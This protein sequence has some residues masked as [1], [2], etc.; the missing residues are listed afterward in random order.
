MVRRSVLQNIFREMVSIRQRLEDI[1]TNF[2][3]WSI[4]PLDL[5]E[6]ELIALPDHLRR[7]IV[8]VSSKGECDASQVSCVTGRCRAVESNYLNQLSRMGWLD[9]RRSSKSVLYRLMSEVN[10]Q[11][12][13][14]SA[15]NSNLRLN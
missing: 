15:R 5:P 11:E 2:S 10:L 14:L 13:T 9:K 4:R 8:V 3:K 6:S 7:T 12:T 1:E